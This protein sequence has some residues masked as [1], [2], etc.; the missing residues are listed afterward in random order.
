[1]WAEWRWGCRLRECYRVVGRV[2][3]GAGTVRCLRC[4]SRRQLPTVRRRRP[5]FGAG[6]AEWVCQ[7]KAGDG[8][9]QT[10]S[11]E[12]CVLSEESPCEPG[13]FDDGSEVQPQ[14]QQRR[15][16]CGAKRQLE[17]IAETLEMLWREHE[18]GVRRLT[19]LTARPANPAVVG[20]RG[21]EQ[22]PRAR[23]DGR[24]ATG[25]LLPEILLAA[26]WS[27]SPAA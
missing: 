13:L 18:R 12:G 20:R 24:R 6:S 10:R 26:S 22:Q 27:G 8:V 14:G 4:V 2:P 25:E 19:A 1:M 17:P 9:I 7:G 11:R 21:Q 23:S 16:E 15:A 5:K 3:G